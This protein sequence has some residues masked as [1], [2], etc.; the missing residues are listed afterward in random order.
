MINIPSNRGNYP[1]TQDR[2]WHYPL[3]QKQLNSS[4][5]TNPQ[6]SPRD[7]QPTSFLETQKSSTLFF[8]HQLASN[9]FGQYPKFLSDTVASGWGAPCRQPSSP[10]QQSKRADYPLPFH[11][12]TPFDLPEPPDLPLT[13]LP[14]QSSDKSAQNPQFSPLSQQNT[15][16]FRRKILCQLQIHTDEKKFNTLYDEIRE[17]LN[18]QSAIVTEIVDQL[19]RE[20]KFGVQILE[21]A[22]TENISANAEQIPEAIAIWILNALKNVE[23]VKI[24]SLASNA[25]TGLSCTNG[26]FVAKIFALM[27]IDENSE[28]VA[29][30]LTT[31]SVKCAAKLLPI[32]PPATQTKF[33][34]QMDPAKASGILCELCDSNQLQFPGNNLKAVGVENAIEVLFEMDTENA[35]NIL[36]QM[37]DFKQ[38]R[39][40]AIILAGMPS[41]SAADIF[42][43]I[44]PLIGSVLLSQMC[45]CRH[46]T[47]AAEI[48]KLMD[49]EKVALIFAAMVLSPNIKN[50]VF[51]LEMMDSKIIIIILQ[52]FLA[53]N[54]QEVAMELFTKMNAKMM[55]NV[56][57][58]LEEEGE[59]VETLKF[60]KQL[61]QENAISVFK[62]MSTFNIRG[63]QFAAVLL[64]KVMN[65]RMAMEVLVALG[66]ESTA[67][68]LKLMYEN[69]L[70][71]PGVLI[72]LPS[73][74]Q[75]DKGV[76]ILDAI[77]V[78]SVV[79]IVLLICKNK[80]YDS[81]AMITLKSESILE[82]KCL[83]PYRS[84][85]RI[86]MDKIKARDAVNEKNKTE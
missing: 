64:A 49:I 8:N 41:K 59:M 70:Y 65:Q 37:V 25:L 79:S 78:K 63:N 77:G 76:K 9:L 19:M 14:Y 67:N 54:R 75:C 24:C 15:M 13:L 10:N 29:Y 73:L 86:E 39:C 31:A 33:L 81:A 46:A 57:L 82:K 66:I 36:A 84:K 44:D 56:L 68:I 2:Q 58:A 61:P 23:D 85:I 11:T 12:S 35:T 62:T 6:N 47:G 20:S 4:E 51:I 30:L 28:N 71:Q 60:F 17:K 40:A 69:Q 50:A 22:Y 16:K 42:T 7:P 5:K 55:V 3:E 43:V 74:M 1:S 21:K 26:E 52:K 72:I 32:L 27:K 80:A 83:M 53:L 48:A 18:A 45:V 34:S 38:T